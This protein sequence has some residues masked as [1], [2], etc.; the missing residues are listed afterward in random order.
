MVGGS[1]R[2][3][4]TM[5]V[6]PD[7][8]DEYKARHANVPTALRELFRAV[9]IH[10]YSIFIDGTRLFAILESKDYASARARMTRDGTW[11]EWQTFIAPIMD[12]MGENQATSRVIDEVFYLE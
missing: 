7:Q 11:L 5:Q 10:D 9:G 3:A 12:E 1:G 2:I 4:F 8:V 6:K